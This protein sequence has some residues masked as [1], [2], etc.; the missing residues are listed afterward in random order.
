MVVRKKMIREIWFGEEDGKIMLIG[1]ILIIM[2]EMMMIRI[3][4]SMR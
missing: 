1:M 4:R 3:W 2:V